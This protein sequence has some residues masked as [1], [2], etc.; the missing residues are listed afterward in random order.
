MFRFSQNYAYLL[1]NLFEAVI[2]S[3]E[4]VIL[5]EFIKFF[6]ISMEC[7]VFVF[8]RLPSCCGA[9]W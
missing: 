8:I 5:Y 7:Y 9:Y 1:N 4:L 2:W 6:H 3:L